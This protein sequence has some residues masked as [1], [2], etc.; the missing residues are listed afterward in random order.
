MNAL[1]AAEL[2][3]NAK[4]AGLTKHRAALLKDIEA[5]AAVGENHI[6]LD[7]PLQEDT[8]TWLTGLGYKV[9][10]PQQKYFLPSGAPMSSMTLVELILGS[11][12]Y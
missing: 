4:E 5:A 3:R 12:S 7:T 1:Q 8:I 11:I 9:V 6:S 2:A 10:Q